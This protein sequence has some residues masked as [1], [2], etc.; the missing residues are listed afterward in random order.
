MLL[1]NF[2]AIVIVV[3]VGAVVLFTGQ[4]IF[5]S[6]AELG[7]AIVSKK[8][9]G[10]PS[11]GEDPQDQVKN[12]KRELVVLNDQ[13]KMVGPD[14]IQ[15][16]WQRL[17]DLWNKKALTRAKAEQL[18]QLLLAIYYRSNPQPT[19]Q[20]AQPTAQKSATASLGELIKGVKAEIDHI[21][22]RENVYLTKEHYHELKKRLDYLTSQGVPDLGPV[23]Y[24]HLT[25]PTTPYV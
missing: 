25:L 15:R 23:S 1:K 22:A 4:P 20:K 9:S 8:S 7:T 2:I 14:H 11:R 6:D 21:G 24:T 13:G 18:Y 5:N 10:P 19:A 16:L 3:V 17:V 12:L